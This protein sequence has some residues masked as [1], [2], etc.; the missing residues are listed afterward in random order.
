MSVFIPSDDETISDNIKNNIYPYQSISA[1][2]DK[3][4]RYNLL[5]RDR[6][7]YDYTDGCHQYVGTFPDK[8]FML[9]NESVLEVFD[10]FYKFTTT[11]NESGD[12]MLFGVPVGNQIV[13]VDVDLSDIGPVLSQTPRDMSYK[14]YNVELFESPS[15]FNSGNN[16]NDLA[17]LKTEDASVY[18]YPFWGDTENSEIAISRQDVKL[19]YKFEPTCVFMGSIITDSGKGM[20]MKNCKSYKELGKMDT[21][22]TGE[23]TIEMIRKTIDDTVENVQIKGNA[24]INGDGVWC[25]QIPMNLDYMVTDEFGN[26]VQTDDLT[27]GIPTRTKA[28]FRIGFDDDKETFVYKK[29]KTKSK[30]SAYYLVPNNPDVSEDYEFGENTRDESF[31]DMFM[32]KVYSVKNY[33]PRFQVGKK[34]TERRFTGIKSIND[35][36]NNNPLPFNSLYSRR[37]IMYIVTCIVTKVFFALMPVYNLLLHVVRLVTNILNIIIRTILIILNFY[38]FRWLKPKGLEE[39]DVSGITCLYI[40][41]Y[42]EDSDKVFAPGCKNILG[43]ISGDGLLGDTNNHLKDEGLGKV[44]DAKDKVVRR[45]MLKCLRNQLAKDTGAINFDFYDDWLNGVL[46][47]PQFFIKN[48]KKTRRKFLGLFGK[49]T[50]KN[51]SKYC[52]SKSSYR[53]TKIVNSCAPT[54]LFD[55]STGDMVAIEGANDECENGNCVKES[56][57]QNCTKGLIIN[58]VDENDDEIFYYNIGYNDITLLSTGIIL[59]GGL[60]ECDIDGIPPLQKYLQST[61]FKQIPDMVET[62]DE[63]DESELSSEEEENRTMGDLKNGEVEITGWDWSFRGGGQIHPKKVDDFKFGDGGLF[64]GLDCDKIYSRLK[65]C[66][67]AERLCE[68]GVSVD[69]TFDRISGCKVSRVLADGYISK[70]SLEDSEVRQMFATLNSNNLKTKVVDGNLKY[71]FKYLY[72]DNFDGKLSGDMKKHHGNDDN[73][74]TETNKRVDNYFE[75]AEDKITD[76]GYLGA[77]NREKTSSDYLK[78]RCGIDKDSELKVNFIGEGNKFIKYVNSYYF[79]FGLKTGSTALDI[80]NKNFYSPC[81]KT[82]KKLFDVKTTITGKMYK[83]ACSPNMNNIELSVVLKEKDNYSVAITD[84]YNEIIS[85]VKEYSNVNGFTMSMGDHNIEKGGLYYMSITNSFGQTVKSPITIK[86]EE[87][88]SISLRSYGLRGDTSKYEDVNRMKCSNNDGKKAK[89]ELYIKKSEKDYCNI[90]DFKLEIVRN[91]TNDSYEIDLSELSNSMVVNNDIY[92]YTFYLTDG[93]HTFTV[94]KTNSNDCI[95]IVQ[96]EII[97]ERTEDLELLINNISN[98]TFKFENMGNA[99]S[100]Y[101]AFKNIIK[102]LN[103]KHTNY[104]TY[105]DDISNEDIKAFN[106]SVLKSFVYINDEQKM[107]INS[108]GGL[109]T[110]VCFISGVGNGENLIQNAISRNTLYELSHESNPL[111][112]KLYFVEEDGLYYYYKDNAFYTDGKSIWT[113]KDDCSYSTNITTF[114]GVNTG[115]EESALPLI[116]DGDSIPIYQ[117][118]TSPKGISFTI[119]NINRGNNCGE[120]GYGYRIAVVDNNGYGNSVPKGLTKIIEDNFKNIDNITLGVFETLKNE[121]YLSLKNSIL[122]HTLDCRLTLVNEF[123]RTSKFYYY[124]T[125]NLT[126][127]I[128]TYQFNTNIQQ[129]YNGGIKKIQQTITFQNDG[130][131]EE[132]SVEENEEELNGNLNSEEISIDHNNYPNLTTLTQGFNIVPNDV[133]CKLE[134]ESLEEGFEDNRLTTNFSMKTDLEMVLTNNVS[135][136]E[137]GY[138]LEDN[139]KPTLIFKVINSEYVLTDNDTCYLYETD[140]KIIDENDGNYTS[141]ISD[142]MKD[143]GITYYNDDVTDKCVKPEDFDSSNKIKDNTDFTSSKKKE[144]SENEFEYTDIDITNNYFSI[145]INKYGYRYFSKAVNIPSVDDIESFIFSDN[146]FIINTQYYMDTFNNGGMSFKGVIYSYKIEDGKIVEGLKI[147]DDVTFTYTIDDDNNIQK[148]KVNVSLPNINLELGSK[149]LVYITDPSGLTTKFYQ[150]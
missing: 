36:G 102:D 122:Y 131:Y 108:N 79:Y 57:S 13:H 54:I 86:E 3:G 55:S 69:E 58:Y 12:Y 10:K 37:P 2:D 93:T 39:I 107:S 56:T 52:G 90:N 26:M 9:N 50:T 83:C 141:P 61:S 121:T 22:V 20:I 41:S 129:S 11:T 88:I 33:I 59:L 6:G 150:K 17:Q 101:E 130:V 1:E 135:I 66:V 62:S 148:N 65:S 139:L 112:D 103:K 115:D 34:P 111:T 78:F 64:V 70:D 44:D 92:T 99:K 138:S 116:H 105:K 128:F 51:V 104:I 71:D 16:L 133:I 118:N 80:F 49:K 46:Y 21:L 38:P 106:I 145:F 126:R 143:I 95:S 4:R 91:G 146:S 132:G 15:M 137:D 136:T 94:S 124:Y 74:I 14:G 73:N 117:I 29:K 97:I 25:Y 113:T 32:N 76:V 96:D 109:P 89:V 84:Q 120:N 43:G 100:Y 77:Y 40:T 119:K 27:K 87:I 53:N 85:E 123:N 42:C 127:N 30:M 19:Q 147:R 28:R 144:D 31:V 149:L 114:E 24:L 125:T 45:V 35:Y 98:Q 48:K 75:S 7:N 18:V 142:I 82:S 23:G 63:E 47:A 8:T 81:K 60:N 134:V 5:P 110:R 140:S 68:I 72:P 67:N